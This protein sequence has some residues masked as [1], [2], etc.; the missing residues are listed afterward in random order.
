MSK[1]L[2]FILFSFKIISLSSNNKILTNKRNL[3]ETLKEDENYNEEDI[4]ILHTNDVHCALNDNIGYDGLMLYKKELLKRYKN[5]LTV[6][7]GDHIQG[8]AYGYLSKGIEII[9]IMNLIGY[10]VVTFGNHEFD[11]GL[12]NLEKCNE[13]LNCGYTSA[14]FC[15]RDNKTT[16]F[17]KYVIKEIGNKTIAFIGLTS[18]EAILK[19]YLFTILDDQKKKVYSFLE[20]NKGKEFYETV[21]STINE[22]KQYGADYVIILAHLGDEV[23]SIQFN[24]KELISN[25]NGIS[26]VIDGHSHSV[27]NTTWKNKDGEE[28]PL[29]QTGMELI[30]LGI[31]K[32]KANGNITSELISQIPEPN[33]KTG[34]EKVKRNDTERWVDAEMKNNLLKITENTKLNEIIG[35]N[36]FDLINE[37]NGR[38]ILSRYE[39]TNIGDLITDAIRYIGNADISLMCSRNIKNDLKK[40]DILYKNIINILP[41][42]DEIIVKE[43]KGEDIIDALEYGVRSSPKKSSRFL[44]VSGISF[45]IDISFNSTVEVDEN[46][47]FIGVRGN[48]RVYDI[49]IGK[50]KIDP[51]KKYKISFNNNIGAGGDGYPMFGKYEV[52]LNTHNST[53]EALLNYIKNELNE[54]IPERYN[55]TQERII[56]KPKDTDNDKDKD[57]FPIFLIVIIVII[58]IILFIFGIILFIKKKKKNSDGMISTDLEK[59]HD[60][61]LQLE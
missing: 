59:V 19:T 47:M 7:A 22:T 12:D 8:N 55:N 25:T 4:V 43:V 46:G 40:G 44:Q 10:D 1:I 39:E 17:P 28:I 27:Y 34:A 41:F 35:Y 37:K 18:T 11:Y 30:N 45:K 3:K 24:S 29:V 14:N 13:T 51:N 21:Q 20:G 57:K 5:V 16:V 31:L 26:A 36:S 61:L 33:E 56:I 54:T 42:Y 60:S 6:D 48:R 49:K 53:N 38:S 15:Y 32:I 23:D 52:I 9:N 2:F 50:G 58:V